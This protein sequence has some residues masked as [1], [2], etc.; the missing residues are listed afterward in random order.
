MLSLSAELVAAA[1]LSGAAPAQRI[2]NLNWLAGDWETS[3]SQQW[4]EEHWN[5]PRAR[6][7]LGTSRSGSGT[8]M[9]EYEF[10]RITHDTDGGLTYWG[11][12]GGKTPVPFR[13]VR[14]GPMLAVFENPAHD[15]PQRITYRRTGSK[16]VATISD[17]DGGKA[18]SWTYRRK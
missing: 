13:L 15:Y 14:S 8:T 5:V 1:L 17:I 7:T 2:E 18:M 11:S 4:T 3:P 12:P 10:L 6:A 9:R 16:L